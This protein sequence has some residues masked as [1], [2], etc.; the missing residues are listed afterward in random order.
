[1]KFV[2]GKIMSSR[3]KVTFEGEL[4]EDLAGLLELPDKA[5][6]AFVLMAHC[7]T[8]GKDIASASRIARSLVREDYAVLRFDFTGLGGSDGDFANTNFSSNVGDLVAAAN[9][10]RTRYQAPQL[11]IGHSLGGTAV[12]AAAHHIKE[13]KGVVTIGSPAAPDHVEHQFMC[14]ISEI[15]TQGEA[16]VELAGRKFVIKKQFVDDIRAQADAKH[17][18]DLRCAILIFH[19]PL[20]RTVKIKEAEMIYAS[21]KHPKSFVSLDDADHLLTQPEDAKY[22]ADVIASWATRYLS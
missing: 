4:G 9:F 6:K 1:M 18:A 2:A 11:L 21:A 3:V 5:P 16:E 10:L 22:V 14:D 13:V 12:L 17:I 20:D 7:F 15:E 19:S 8:C